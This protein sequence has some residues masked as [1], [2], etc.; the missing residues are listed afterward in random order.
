MGIQEGY[1]SVTLDNESSKLTPFVTPFRFY[2][3]LTNP[4]GNHVSGDSYNK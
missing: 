2:R 4:Q 3:Y 1:H